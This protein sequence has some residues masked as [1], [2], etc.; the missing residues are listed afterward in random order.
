MGI[1]SKY[2]YHAKWIIFLIL[3]RIHSIQSYEPG[4]SNEI[5]DCDCENISG[6]ISVDCS[7][8]GLTEMPEFNGA[9]VYTNKKKIISLLFFRYRTIFFSLYRK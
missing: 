7:G 3:A 9:Q 4:C 6:A 8:R 1:R 5:P 2:L